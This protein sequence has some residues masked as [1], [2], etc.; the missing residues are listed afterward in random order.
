VKPVRVAAGVLAA[1]L[2]RP[3]FSSA[4]SL[5]APGQII[6]AALETKAATDSLEREL[7]AAAR[8]GTL[9]VGYS[10]PSTG[11][12]HQ[13]CV[14]YGADGVARVMLEAPK[15]FSVLVRFEAGVLSRIRTSTPECVIDA[16]GL[17]VI[18]LT[19]VR[20]AE[21]VRWFV[22]TI[23]KAADRP[24]DRDRGL[25]DSALSALAWHA[26]D[27][28]TRAVVAL[29]KN[30]ARPNVRSRSL[31]WLSQR[32]SAETIA[33]I[34]ESVNADPEVEVKKKAVF[35]L[36]QL[37][38][39]QGVPLLIDVA[40]RHPNRDV[41]RQAMMW[42]GQSKDPRAVSFFEEVLKKP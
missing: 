35:A 12:R 41:R 30:D 3:V 34:R 16:G 32:A 7:G 17:P 10:V 38:A 9:W 21:S 37:P 36:S 1:A 29:A 14:P 40:R 8:R 28:A 5:P 22:S 19:G 18:W 2:L 31:F 15:E 25:I 4:Q 42:L 24:G 23:G 33:T 6:N 27:E 13:T 39:N 20:P 11:G 26:G